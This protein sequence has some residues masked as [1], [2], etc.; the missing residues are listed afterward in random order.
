MIL[1]FLILLFLTLTILSCSPKLKPALEEGPSAGLFPSDIEAVLIDQG[2]SLLGP[3]EPSICINP[4]NPEHIVAGAILDKV[5]VSRDGGRSWSTARLRSSLG[6]Y[7]DPV[8]RANYKGDFFY[9]HLS[10]PDG[11]P[12]ASESF[13]DRI[14]V[15]KSTDGGDTWNDGSYTLPRSPKDQDKQWMAIDPRTNHIYMT[16]T[17][18]DKYDS[19]DPADKSRI[20]FSKS[21][22]DGDSWSEPLTLSQKEGNCLD[23]DDTTEGAVPA[24]GPNGEIY[25]T[26]AYEEKLYFDKSLDRGETWLQEDLVIAEQ[27]GGWNLS[28]PGLSRTNGM[29]IT[30]ADRSSGPHKGTIYV[31]WSDQRNGADD[32]DIWLVKSSDE[33]NSW[34]EPIRVNDDLPGKQQ[35]LSWME[36]DQET[37]YIY[38]VFYD[39]RNHADNTTDVYLAVSTD[40]GLTF[41]NKKINSKSF[42]P[43]PE[44]FFGD[45]NDISVVDGKVRPIWTQLEG[46]RLSVWTALVNMDKR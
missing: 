46:K 30:I 27:I 1:R 41:E 10:N 6:V 16:W 13:L 19:P 22:D 32:T 38:V 9:A 34:S 14:I 43:V 36:I 28:I 29:P 42:V 8:V 5:Y 35:F 2:T 3:C 12:Y 21:I 20:L 37:G 4:T 24:V 17:E 26:W 11:Q 23:D 18:F 31:N 33:G 25:V 44:V 7:G 45:Y 15:Q 40:G 39:R